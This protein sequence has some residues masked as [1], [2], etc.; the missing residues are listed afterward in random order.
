MRNK[1]KRNLFIS[2]SISLLILTVSSTAS[3]L[4]IQSLLNSNSLVDHTRE[5]ITCLNKANSSLVQA[6]SGTRGFLITGDEVFV[7]NFIADE[8]ESDRLYE[9]LEVLTSDN[10]SQQI[11]LS[12]LKPLRINFFDYL[13]NRINTKKSGQNTFSNDLTYGKRIMSNISK[14]NNRI[15]ENENKLLKERNLSAE[16]YGMFTVILIVIAFVISFLITVTFFIRVLRDY[17]ERNELQKQLIE[18]DQLI[19]DRIAVVSSIANN[20]SKGNYDI[21]VDTLQRDAL[22]SLAG[23]LNSMRLSLRKSF[24]LLIEK[25]WHQTG[26][27]ELNSVM[28]GEKS[29]EILTKDVLEFLC[30]YTNSS[31]GT[32]YVIDEGQL[33]LSATYSYVATKGRERLSRGEGLVGQSLVSGKILEL[34]SFNPENITVNYAMGEMQPSHIIAVPLG[35]TDVEGVIELANLKEFTDLELEF[36]GNVSNNIGITLRATQNRIRLKELL[37]ETQSQSEELKVQHTEMES[38]NAEL[39]TQTE[40]LQASEEELRVQQEE[41]QQTNEEL[42]ERSVLLEERNVEIQKKSEDLE[43]STRYKSE[44]LANMSHELRTPLN[45]ILLLS[46][47]LSENNDANMNDEQI[48]FAKVIQSSGNG[49]LGLIDEILDLSKIEAGKMDLELVDVST[50]EITDTLRNLFTQVAIEKKIEFK[51]IDDKAP[52]VI[53]TDKMR[54]EQILKNLISNAIK[55]TTVGQVSIEIKKDDVDDKSICFV[56]KDTGI[57]IPLDKQP[58]I[59]EAFQQA[60][61]S[62]KRKYGGTGLGLSISRELAKLLGGEIVLK[63]ILGEGSEFIFSMPMIYSSNARVIYSNVIMQEPEVEKIKDNNHNI[64]ENKYLSL[65]IP[66][67]IEDDRNAIIENDKVILI[68]EDDINFAKSLLAFSR[69]K[70]YKAIVAVRGDYALGFALLYKPVGI[71]LDIELPI[72]NGWQ[73]LDELKNNIQ[74]KHIPVH[75]MSS[76]KFKQESLL[77]G[78]VNF[79]EKPVAFE[80]MPE[81]FTRIE[82]IISKEYKKVLIIED[83]TKHA[84]ALAYF[85]ESNNINSDIKSDIND[86]IE[87]LTKDDLDCVIL[88]MGIP[89]KNA[90]NILDTIKKSIG[91]ENLPVIVFT[92][93]SLSVNEELKIK[94]YADS[95]VVKTAHS[96]QRMLDEVSLFLHVV[97]E[98]KKSEGKNKSFKRLNILNNVLFEKTV[99]VVDDD[100]R[101]IFSL[102]KALEVFKMN[103]ITAIDGEEALKVL[104]QYPQTDVILLDMMMPNMDG[105]E[106]AQRIRNN[107]KFKKLPVIAVTAKAMIGDREKCIK[108]GASDYITKPIDIDQLLSLLR[109]WLYDNN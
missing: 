57:G 32:F 44:F 82:K 87:A 79:L 98:N 47:L 103:I 45:S 101:N 15:E 24:H 33:Q 59:F 71:L 104:E 28:L 64:I 106:T 1:F 70:G 68:V 29:M 65:V 48:E 38:I 5:V 61:G 77:K 78:A 17:T 27:A 108:A 56:V 49:L 53:K 40:K 39:E 2:S 4:S 84:N 62:T 92:G 73:V 95:I 26:V 46:R 37:E 58:L 96:F 12:Q 89:D 41:L 90:Y 75:I 20:I 97:E 13:K 85:L 7:E 23:S 19:A 94:K 9:Q 3:F 74:T 54:L 88:D 18:K 14:I 93:K 11:N 86:S 72:V 76:H 51:I 10:P 36:L 50:K 63:S 16:N 55:F 80:E 83:N 35:D 99:L 34:K 43:L 91:L 109:V 8:K 102:T 107:N 66:D 6:Q 42:S 105:Y 22:G 21:K 69:K 25:E 31:V 100:V 52:I 30:N 60:D 67:E 81:I